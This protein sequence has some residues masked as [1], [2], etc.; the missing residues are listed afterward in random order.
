MT[1]C[2]K[3]LPISRNRVALHLFEISKIGAYYYFVD[4]K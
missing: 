1:V 3:N 2:R 4:V